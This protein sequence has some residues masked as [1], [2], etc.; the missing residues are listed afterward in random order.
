MGHGL[1]PGARPFF[2]RALRRFR[3]LSAPPFFRWLHYRPA[4]VRRAAPAYVELLELGVVF[5]RALVLVVG[6]ELGTRLNSAKGVD[7]NLPARDHR[8]AIGLAGMIDEARV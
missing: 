6:G 1:V 3:G 4:T 7:E 2:P 5:P 8:L